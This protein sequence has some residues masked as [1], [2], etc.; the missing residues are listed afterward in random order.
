MT[1]RST[2]QKLQQGLKEI[3]KKLNPEGKR[4]QKDFKRELMLL[5]DYNGI[6]VRLEHWNA[7]WVHKQRRKKGWIDMKRLTEKAFEKK[8]KIKRNTTKE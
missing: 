8:K 3:E 1:L 2:D 5:E 6:F 7:E 4:T